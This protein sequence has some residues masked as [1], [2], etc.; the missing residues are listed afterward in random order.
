M[1]SYDFTSETYKDLLF[2]RSYSQPAPGWI[3][4]VYYARKPVIHAHD[5]NK[6]N[7]FECRFL[8]E[9]SGSLNGDVSTIGHF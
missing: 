3:D 5:L 2:D 9:D 7:I 4:G 1:I 6:K 8:E